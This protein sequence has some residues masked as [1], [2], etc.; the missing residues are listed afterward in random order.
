MEMTEKKEGI[1]ALRDE[2]LRKASLAT[3]MYIESLEDTL[4]RRNEL[5]NLMTIDNGFIM[6]LRETE[7]N[8]QWRGKIFDK[9]RQINKNESRK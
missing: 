8:A 6:K 9:A 2:A 7:S 1:E 3:R 5:I 4:R